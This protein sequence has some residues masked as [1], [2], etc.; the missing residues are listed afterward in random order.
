MSCAF[1]LWKRSFGLLSLFEITTNTT[2][3]ILWSVRIF[4][5]KSSPLILINCTSLSKNPYLHSRRSSIPVWLCSPEPLDT[6]KND[7]VPHQG[8]YCSGRMCDRPGPDCRMSHTLY[9][10][11]LSTN[12]MVY[13][14]VQSF[15]KYY[16]CSGWNWYMRR[17]LQKPGLWC[18]D[19]NPSLI[20]A[21]I[22]TSKS[23]WSDCRVSCTAR[24]CAISTF[25]SWFLDQ[26]G[27]VETEGVY[28]SH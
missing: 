13:Q 4:S 3:Y 7:T 5:K 2:Y 19:K 1:L 10:Q 24:G 26:Y 25:K 12:G 8:W 6:C 27:H 23:S 14:K 21:K 16:K 22:L 9:T 18:N 28:L 20:K 17:G 15:C 11:S